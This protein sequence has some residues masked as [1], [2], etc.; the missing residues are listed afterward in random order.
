MEKT[1]KRSMYQFIA[2]TL[3]DNADVVAFCEHEIELLDKKAAAAKVYSN[4]KRAEG[5][6]LKDVIYEVLSDTDF[7]PI[8]DIAASI[9][10]DDITAS[11]VVSR[12]TTLVK[13]GLA[14]KDSVYVGATETSKG[15]KVMGYRKL[16]TA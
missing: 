4:K 10:G 13:E 5:D 1:T 2:E 6:A 11:K 16:V 12:L 15:R 9:E 14:E 3:A 8:A 7:M